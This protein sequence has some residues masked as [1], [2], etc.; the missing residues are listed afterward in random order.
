MNL[1][2]FLLFVNSAIATQQQSDVLIIDE[3]IVYLRSYPLERLFFKSRPFG[4]T[5]KTA[6]HTGCW[7]GYVAVWTLIEDK[8]YLKGIKR[9]SGD[10]NGV[11]KENIEEFFI[12]NRIR[13]KTKDG[14]IF[15][16]WVSGEFYTSK[17]KWGAYNTGDHNEE[18][19]RMEIEK[20]NVISVELVNNRN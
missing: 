8:F 10:D 2:I 13:Y 20:G 4:Y 18:N 5:R 7:R 17:E 11:A 14:M 1:I 3:Q 19:I 9:C 6:P 16:S 12:K 15:A